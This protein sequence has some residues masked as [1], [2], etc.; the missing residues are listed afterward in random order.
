MKHPT[1][2]IYI[3]IFLLCV[4]SDDFMYITNF[5]GFVM[6]CII[7]SVLDFDM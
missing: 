2:V 1:L 4:F 6:V 7:V 5:K 3:C